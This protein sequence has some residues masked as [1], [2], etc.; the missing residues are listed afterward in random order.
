MASS[1]AEVIQKLNHS[2]NYI[3]Q[4]YALYQKSPDAESVRDA[5]AAYERSLI[6]PDSRFD[7]YLRGDEQAI[8]TQEKHGYRVFK[9]YGC[10]SCHQ[11]VAVGGNLFEKFGVMNN[12]GRGS[13]KADLGRFNVTGLEKDKYVFKVPS[14]RNVE[15]TSPYFHDG[16]VAT[17]EDAIRTMVKFQLGRSLSDSDVEDV[18][19]FLRTLTG[20]PRTKQ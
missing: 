11:G 13:S 10:A 15:L 14:L 17:L 3:N 2:S 9:E 8:T 7:L 4:F 1:W 6:T 5:I 18:A 12:E 16:S 20:R 19:M